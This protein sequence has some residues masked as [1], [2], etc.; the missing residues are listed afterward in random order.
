MKSHLHLQSV[1]LLAGDM[2]YDVAKAVCA[3]FVFIATHA[4]TRILSRLPYI[5]V[6]FFMIKMVMFRKQFNRDSQKTPNHLINCSKGFSIRMSM[7]C[8]NVHNA[9]LKK[10]MAKTWPKPPVDNIT[11]VPFWPGLP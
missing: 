5:G 3:A 7:T 10:N 2:D 4:F 11:K 8:L 1:V 9:G 6:N